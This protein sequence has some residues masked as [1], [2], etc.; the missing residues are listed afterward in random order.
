MTAVEGNR[1]APFSIDTTPKCREGR[2]SFP[3][4]APLYP[5]SSPYKAECYARRLQVPFFESLVWLVLG[6]NPALPGHWRTLYTLGQWSIPYTDLKTKANRF[7]HAKWQRR[8]NNNIFNKLFLIKPNLGEC[9]PTFIKSSI[10][11]YFRKMIKPTTCGSWFGQS[12]KGRRNP[13]QYSTKKLPL[14]FVENYY[15]DPQYEFG[16]QTE[17]TKT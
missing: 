13:R 14:L 9:K 12:G 2:Y 4:I 5:W 15:W 3:W 1:K 7:L 17:G 11:I 6:V 8:L 16:D 10:K